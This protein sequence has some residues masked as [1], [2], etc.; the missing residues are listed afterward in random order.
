MWFVF[1]LFNSG[2]YS[3][4]NPSPG[5]NHLRRRRITCILLVYGSAV[6]TEPRNS[7]IPW[8]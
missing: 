3:E 6:C 5:V 4:G 2:H 8:L 7:D 1:R